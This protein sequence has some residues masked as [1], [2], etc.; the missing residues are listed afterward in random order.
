MYNDPTVDRLA[1]KEDLHEFSHTGLNHD[2]KHYGNSE[3]PSLL[4]LAPYFE[5]S[6]NPNRGVTFTLTAEF[7]WLASLNAI[8]LVLNRE[9]KPRSVPNMERQRARSSQNVI[10]HNFVIIK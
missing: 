6:K 3:N 4:Y 5:G 7:G 1:P 2:S 8:D 10:L 9:S